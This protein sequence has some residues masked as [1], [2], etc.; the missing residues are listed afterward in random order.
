MYVPVAHFLLMEGCPSKS[1]KPSLL[2]SKDTAIEPWKRKILH[3]GSRSKDGGRSL[4]MLRFSVLQFGGITLHRCRFGEV[5]QVL[6]F[7]FC[8]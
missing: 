1:Q 2:P 6:Y 4:A 7:C 8:E 5:V 3:L